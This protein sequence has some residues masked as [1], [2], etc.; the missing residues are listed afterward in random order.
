MFGKY[1]RKLLGAKTIKIQMWDFRLYVE[2]SE[3]NK[4]FFDLF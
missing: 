3:N 4:R 1:L 2:F